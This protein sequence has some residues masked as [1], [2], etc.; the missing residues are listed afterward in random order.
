MKKFTNLLLSCL[1]LFVIMFSSISCERYRDKT[2]PKLE[3][4]LSWDGQVLC[5]YHEYAISDFDWGCWIFADAFA[6][7]QEK[8]PHYSIVTFVQEYAC[9]D[10]D[11]YSKPYGVKMDDVVYIPAYFNGVEIWHFGYRCYHH[12]GETWVKTGVDCQKLYLSFA[13]IS[14]DHLSINADVIFV[15]AAR[16]KVV[17]AMESDLVAA[18]ENCG[19]IFMPYKAFYEFIM[20]HSKQ[21]YKQLLSYQAKFS[22]Y[23][24]YYETTAIFTAANTAYMFN[25]EGSPNEDYFFI[26]DFE[27]GGLIED[28]PYEPLR[29]GYTFGGWYKDS[30]CT[31]KW[32]FSAD[33]LPEAAYDEEGNFE[34]VET[35]LYAKWTK[36]N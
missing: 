31:E 4:K 1:L 14:I 23:V 29:E 34:Y 18:S 26:N 32:D 17:D 25:Y 5:G 19:Y 11:D 21:H 13:T 36:N 7:E 15:P 20:N 33:K 3:D 27:R 22:G 30:A 6:E 9:D 16:I 8:M 28:T 10:I 35:R 24:E 2:A 12:Y